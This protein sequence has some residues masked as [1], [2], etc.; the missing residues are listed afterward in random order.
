ALGPT[1]NPTIGVLAG[2]GAAAITGIL[3][4][5][6]LAWLG[7]RWRVD[8]IIA[9]IVINIGA[10]GIASVLFLRVLTKQTE[11]NTPP[12]VEAIRIPVL[13]EIPVIGPIL[14]QGSPY[15]YFA[16]LV[17]VAFAYMLYR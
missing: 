1:A 14:F 9:G 17:M 8:Q 6:L 11:L 16:L 4:S 13:S 7:I 2:V 10:V 12:T 15:L 5:L 3:V